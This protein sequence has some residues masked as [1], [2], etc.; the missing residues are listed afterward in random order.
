VTRP[1]ETGETSEVASDDKVFTVA[2]AGC[3]F[4]VREIDTPTLDPELTQSCPRVDVELT[5]P[6]NPLRPKAFSDLA[7]RP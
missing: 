1:P 5:T 6:G 3:M 2:A 4:H 7:D